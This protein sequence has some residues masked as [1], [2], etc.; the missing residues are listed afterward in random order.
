M[1]GYNYKEKRKIM[2]DYL[3]PK[4]IPKFYSSNSGKIECKIGENKEDKRD[5]IK[6]L[7]CYSGKV[8]QR[9]RKMLNI[10]QIIMRRRKLM[11][12]QKLK[13]KLN[14]GVRLIEQRLEKCIAR[15]VMNNLETNKLDK[16]DLKRSRKRSRKIVITKEIVLQCNI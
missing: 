6:K 11:K 7:I 8:V 14:S 4:I 3:L 15:L 9:N 1:M 13:Q 5:I 10:H 2:M 16:S 12:K